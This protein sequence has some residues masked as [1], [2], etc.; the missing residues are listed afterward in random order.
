MYTQP[1]GYKRWLVTA[2][3]RFMAYLLADDE[4]EARERF[5]SC[6]Y[7]ELARD[8]RELKVLRAF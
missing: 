2:K 5:W 8:D 3:G 6:F 7:P 1:T 4:V